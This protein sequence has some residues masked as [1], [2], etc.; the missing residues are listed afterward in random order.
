MHNS[1]VRENKSKQ[2]KTKS[3]VSDSGI[4]SVTGDTSTNC[5]S[6]FASILLQTSEIVLENPFN[7][8]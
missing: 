4:K 6:N 3:E 2:G 1:A 5:S 7:K 8:K